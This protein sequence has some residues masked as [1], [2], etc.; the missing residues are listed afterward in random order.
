MGCLTC[1]MSEGVIP[2]LPE[3]FDHAALTC[4]QIKQTLRKLFDTAREPIHLRYERN[5]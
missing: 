2:S 1:L 4:L 3:C 5:G